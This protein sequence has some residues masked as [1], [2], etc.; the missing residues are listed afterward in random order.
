MATIISVKAQEVFNF[1]R[2]F[3]SLPDCAAVRFPKTSNIVDD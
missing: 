3:V 1:L 2:V